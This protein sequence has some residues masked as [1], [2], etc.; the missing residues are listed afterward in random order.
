LFTV[1]SRYQSPVIRPVHPRV[2]YARSRP[3]IVDG[4]S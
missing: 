3:W 1:E 2:E 4:L